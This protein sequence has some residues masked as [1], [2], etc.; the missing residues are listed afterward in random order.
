MTLQWLSIFSVVGKRPK[1][2]KYWICAWL[3]LIKEKWNLK[4]IYSK[5][6]D[7]TIIIFQNENLSKQV[8]YLMIGAEQTLLQ[9]PRKGTH[10]IEQLNDSLLDFFLLQGHG[11]Y[12]ATNAEGCYI[13][14]RCIRAGN[15]SNLAISKALFSVLCFFFFFIV[16]HQWSTQILRVH[17]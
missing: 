4:L 5:F 9:S 1:C 10:Q 16:V 14:I 8:V 2:S 3:W 6:Q 11:V 7:H 13:V 17:G 12:N 15:M